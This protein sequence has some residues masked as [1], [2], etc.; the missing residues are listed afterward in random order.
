MRIREN[1]ENHLPFS[2]LGSFP[3]DNNKTEINIG[4]IPKNIKVPSSIKKKQLFRE[5]C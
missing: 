1:E 2:F 5:K 4:D 3:I